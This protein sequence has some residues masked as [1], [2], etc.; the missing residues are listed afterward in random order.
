M[1]GAM[2]A[3]ASE[4]PRCA[5]HGLRYDPRVSPGCV[6]C[7]RA[8]PR[9]RI[10]RPGFAIAAACIALLA[11]PSWVALRRWNPPAKK[12]AG[13]TSLDLWSPIASRF[14][15][16]D[17]ARAPSAVRLQQRYGLQVLVPVDPTV[18]VPLG[19]RLTGRRPSSGVE[20]TLAFLLGAL[21]RLPDS[22]TG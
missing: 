11:V 20:E 14:V 6:L 13:S 22:L 16:L 1:R 17:P 15:V 9:T 8:A 21:A 2:E 12:A 7:R 5:Q 4:L 10:L 19:W 18:D 3:K